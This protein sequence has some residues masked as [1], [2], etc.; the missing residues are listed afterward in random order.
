VYLTVDH[1]RIDH[2]AAILDHDIPPVFG[3][4]DLVELVIAVSRDGVRHLDLLGARILIEYRLLGY[5]FSECL[6]LLCH[7]V[8]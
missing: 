5:L 6:A 2:R 1:G 4:P 7:V 8:V 3:L